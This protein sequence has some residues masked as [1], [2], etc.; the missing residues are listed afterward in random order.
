M[1]MMLLIHSEKDYEVALEA[2]EVLFGKGTIDVMNAWDEKYL[3]S[4]FDGVP[5]YHCTRE[6]FSASIIDILAE[7]TTVLS[8]KSE[9][10]RMLQGNSVS[11]NKQKITLNF[12]VD[13]STLILGKYLIVQT[14][15]KNYHLLV[16]E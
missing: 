10:R 15:K 6:I 2:S 12:N 1:E 5:T 14:G 7:H 3:L 16:V 9:A 11:V 13:E 8:S 4:V